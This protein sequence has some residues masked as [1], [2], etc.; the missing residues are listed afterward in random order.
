M[1][2]NHIYLTDRIVIGE[3]PNRVTIKLETEA[4][5]V[6]FFAPPK[7]ARSVRFVKWAVRLAFKGLLS[8]S[9]LGVTAQGTWVSSKL[10]F[11]H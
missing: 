2:S 1:K 3:Y 10:T 7:Y 6:K 5:I 11:N 8:L 4:E 9:G